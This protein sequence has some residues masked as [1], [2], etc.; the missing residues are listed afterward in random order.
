MGFL[1]DGY[2]L[3]TEEGNYMKF[4]DGENKIRILSEPILGWLDWDDNRQPHRTPLDQKPTKSLSS[5]L[6]A[7]VKHFWAMVVWNY[8]EEKVQIL[9]I[10]QSTIQK[11]INTFVADPDYGSPFDYDIVISKS[12]AEL[13]T[14][15][16]VTP[17]P[18]KPVDPLI[19]MEY[20]PKNYDLTALYRN[21]SP[22]VSQ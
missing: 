6:D 4:R 10:T 13:K 19:A 1:P 18:P 15:Y 12:G 20:N 14:E 3:P 9:E 11:A 22:F 21:E 7:K 8:Q 17:K 16:Q 2:K 5:K